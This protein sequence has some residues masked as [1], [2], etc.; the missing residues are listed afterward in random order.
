MKLIR[1]ILVLL[2]VFIIV[3]YRFRRL[4]YARLLHLEPPSHRVRVFREIRIPMFDGV[5]LAADYYGPS[6]PGRYPTIL[7]RSPYG[8]NEQAG[9]VGRVLAFCA[10]RFAE[11]GYQ[12]VIQDIRG[13]FDS[14]GRFNPLFAE[15]DD[16]RATVE[17]LKRQPWFNGV[18]GMWG[19]SYLG[20]TQWAVAPETPEVQALAASI[21]SSQLHNIIYPDGAFALGLAVRWLKI[22]QL[23]DQT[24]KRPLL[25]NL[26][27]LAQLEPSVQP[28]FNALPVKYVD[29]KVL[30][31]E[32]DV[33]QDWVAHPDPNDPYWH[34]NG[35]NIHIPVEQTAA[36]VHLVAGW[37][38][39]FLREQLADYARLRAAGRNPYL[40]IGPWHHF[41]VTFL[42]PNLRDDLNWFNAH[43]KGD[44][45]Q[46]R[47]RPVRLYI[48]GADE[49]REF[50]SWPP[51]SQERRLYLSSW[52]RL[53]Y[54]VPADG[55]PADY[56]HYDPAN[57]TPAV[58]GAQFHPLAGPRDNRVLEAR[59]DVLTYTTPPL[60]APLEVIGPVR[61][62][63]YVRSSLDHTDFFGRL[64]DVY[65]D[66]RSINI[67]D[68]LL[69]V[70]PGI[71]ER[72]PDGSLRIE[73]DLWATAHCF[74]PGHAVRLQ[75]SSGAH[76]RWNR[77]LGTG[78]SLNSD[79]MRGA[80]QIVY[81]DL[82]HPSALVL[83]MTESAA[84]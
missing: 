71:G 30:G 62:E 23:L 54:A 29:Q 67:C 47:A 55:Q 83:P 66:G 12:I 39:F 46:L 3:A 72:Q 24:W 77:N 8:R 50:D 41:Q 68:G 7:I 75:V 28:A 84:I 80:D 57:P 31:Y 35:H 64:C 81:H 6:E 82:D 21:T 4:I 17:W 65:P 73:I 18:L 44:R 15:K 1:N 43:L 2:G 42:V 11:R 70:A 10:Y 33:F 20:I 53:E 9:I 79:Q 63:L 61:L 69:R 5:S 22:F 74:R 25:L 34:A 37:Y 32:L 40:T 16:G 78:D 26:W 36:P 27:K 52:G 48:M 58:G 76:P 14:W 60:T 45:R 38:D 49:W 59:P 13:R 56:Y 19:P 51:P